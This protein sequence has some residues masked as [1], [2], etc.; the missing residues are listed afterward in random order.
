MDAI[1][2][3]A[4]NLLEGARWTNDEVQSLRYPPY[5]KGIPVKPLEFVLDTQRE[6]LDSIRVAMRMGGSH[7]DEMVITRIDEPVAHLVKLVHLLPASEREYF[8]AAGGAYRFCLESGV[9]AFRYA[10]S[11]MLSR[12]TPERRRDNEQLWSHAAFLAGLYSE[13]IRILSSLSVYGEC[14]GAPRENEQ[15]HPGSM[16]LLDWLESRNIETYRIVWHEGRNTAMAA[17]IV[18]TVLPQGQSSV[19]ADGD[20]AI[21]ATLADALANTEDMKNPLVRVVLTIRGRLIE[22]DQASNPSH[23]G[24][25]YTGL[26]MEP[27]L[28]DAM[29]HL[30]ISRKWTVNQER[31]R[32]W[33]G[34]DGAFLYWPTCAT[35]IQQDL[36]DSQSPFIPRNISTL[37]D[38]LVRAKIV[39]STQSGYIQSIAVPELTASSRRIVEALQLSHPEILFGKELPESLGFPLLVKREFDEEAAL[40]EMLTVPAYSVDENHD[41][42]GDDHINAEPIDADEYYAT[43]NN[44]NQPAPKPKKQGKPKSQTKIEPADQGD[45]Y[46]NPQEL[47]SEED[48][49]DVSQVLLQLTQ[50]TGRTH[51]QTL[52]HADPFGPGDKKAESMARARLI[53]SGLKKLSEEHV[54]QKSPAI[55]QVN[56]T[57]LKKL[58][59][60]ESD[61]TTVFSDAGL[62][63]F[64]DGLPM[65]V[66]TDQGNPRRYL[67]LSGELKDW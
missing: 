66:N 56:A 33:Y 21:L 62:L 48:Q 42:T 8:N 65:G 18:R 32:V 7:N 17:A 53:L 4:A 41:R 1:S 10:E 2:S 51:E 64:V 67:L 25:P 16:P 54:F 36:R 15:W 45:T 61:A 12:A 55:V 24:Q 5:P 6:I 19:L 20:Q 40:S 58:K 23:F 38:I 59:V 13:A 46:V 43:I 37:V 57:G 60:A 49:P 26:H 28:I 35:D 47:E 39:V 29:R 3:G 30:L 14:P 44:E 50:G 11:R 22:R 9:H 34:S 52:P 31:A 27:W 63:I